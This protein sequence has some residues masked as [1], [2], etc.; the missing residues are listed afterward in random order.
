ML[1]NRYLPV[2][3]LG[4]TLVL[5]SSARLSQAATINVPGNFATIQGAIADAG[6]V[7]GDEIVV[8]PGTYNEIIDFL[9]KAITVRSASGD[10]SDTIIDATGVADPGDGL[11]VVRCDNGE[12]AT[13]VLDGFTLTG[14][15]GDTAAF[16][17]ISVGGGMFNNGAS[18]TVTN[19]TFSENTATGGGGIYNLT[20][21]P[22]VT[23]CT[24]SGNSASFGGGMFNAP[25]AARR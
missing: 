9:G 23:N 11:P 2:F 18:P 8:Q 17:G 4:I 14:G 22:T 5:M 10:P 6:T 19:C 3:A 20:S 21:S 25:T 24:F 13:T 7:N 12:T 16:G 15:T 1:S